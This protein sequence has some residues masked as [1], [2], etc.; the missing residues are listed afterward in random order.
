MPEPLD[1]PVLTSTFVE[2]DHTSNDFTMIS[3]IGIQLFVC[4]GLIKYFSK[5]QNTVK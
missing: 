5:R 3:H 4:N 2:Y 1:E